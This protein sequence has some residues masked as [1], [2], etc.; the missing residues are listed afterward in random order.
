MNLFFMYQKRLNKLNETKFIIKWEKFVKDKMRKFIIWLLI[1]WIISSF[2]FGYFI[3]DLAG[4][5][6]GL[7]LTVL[8]A[9]YVG[10]VLVIQSIKFLAYNS[11]RYIKAKM[12]QEG[13]IINSKMASK[14]EE[15][16]IYEDEIIY[17]NVVEYEDE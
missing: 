5:F 12:L 3:F 4:F 9:M 8:F 17:E 14:E 11:D 7:I 13:T 16:F 6:L 2:L 1:L 15:D 10:Y